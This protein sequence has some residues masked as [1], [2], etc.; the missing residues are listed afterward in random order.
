MRVRV[1]GWSVAAL[2]ALL[3]AAVPAVA[4]HSFAMFDMQKEVTFK[5][6]VKEFQWT[7]PHSWVQLEVKN[8]K[9]ETEEWALEALSPNVLSRMGWKRNSLKAGDAVTVV[10]HP[11]RDGSHGGHLVNVTLADGTTIGG[12]Q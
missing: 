1:L 2:S 7:N 5:G 3:V 9:G 4:H 8:D 12:V 10:F 6:V 11:A